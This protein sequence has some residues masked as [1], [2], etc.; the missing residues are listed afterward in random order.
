M[1][2]ITGLKEASRHP[3]TH[4]HTPH[5]LL[6]FIN[7]LIHLQETPWPCLALIVSWYLPKKTCLAHRFFAIRRKYNEDLDLWKLFFT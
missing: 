6:T 5:T 4:A 3:P 2:M 7:L 1:G